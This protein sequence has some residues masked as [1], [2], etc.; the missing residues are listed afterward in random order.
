MPR[1]PTTANWTGRI[2]PVTNRPRYELQKFVNA[3]NGHLRQEEAL[4][5]EQYRADETRRREAP[6]HLRTIVSRWQT[7]GPDLFRFSLDNRE[8]WAEI[9]QYWKTMPT[10][11]VGAPGGGA[12][13]GWNSIPDFDPRREALRWFIE[14]V[15]NPDCGKLAGP[16][17][18][19]GNFYIRRSARN[20]CYC[21]RSCGTKATAEI[22]TAK[23]RNE[24]RAG[25][26]RTAAQ[27]CQRWETTRTTLDWK[28]WVSSSAPKGEITPKFLTRAVNKGELTKPNRRS[29][30]E[31]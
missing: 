8:L 2:V 10:L 18:R 15:F 17:A 7:S 9:F 29:A 11:L 31:T 12:A 5:L 22:A 25:K 24:E 30:K 27:L 23:R 28:Q 26:L 21:S 19:C 3:L 13:I 20:K 16:C 6:I 14:F 4:G 1:K